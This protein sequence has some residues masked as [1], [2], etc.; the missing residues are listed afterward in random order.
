MAFGFP[1][2]HT[3][4]YSAAVGNPADLRTA[5]RATLNA[6]SWSV[7]EERSDQIV[8]GT[9]MNMRSWG[10]KVLVNFLPDSAISVTSKCALVTQCF[11]WGKNKANVNRF[12]AEIGNQVQ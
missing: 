6:L 10:E 1:A 8:A 7:I 5:V 2:Y 4:R 12:M 11:D 9:S 3:E